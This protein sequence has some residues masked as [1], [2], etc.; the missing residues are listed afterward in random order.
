MKIILFSILSFCSQM[1][2]AQPV[3]L[4][5][6]MHQTTL[7]GGCWYMLANCSKKYELVGDSD[8]VNPLHIEEQFVT[9]SVEPAHNAAS[10]CMIG[11]IVHVLQRIDSVRHPVDLPIMQKAFAGTVHRNKAGIW[12]LLTAKGER[13]EFRKTPDA[14]YRKIGTK[15][16][17][18][19]RVLLNKSI[20]GDGM[21]GVLLTGP[22]PIANP[23]TFDSR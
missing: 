2:S 15:I 4:S 21:D 8:I 9:L 1:S 23:K 17:G 18:T 5:G 14:A 16:S 6:I 22:M 10:I 12:Y 20:N 19:F 11:E 13:Y 7:E 3:R